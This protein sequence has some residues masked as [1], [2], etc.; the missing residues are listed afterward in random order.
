MAKAFDWL[1]PKDDPPD[2]IYDKVIHPEVHKCLGR[3]Y[4]FLEGT[5]DEHDN[6]EQVIEESLWAVYEKG[7]DNA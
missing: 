7:A 6:L 3:I 4:N 1:T 2:V 5:Q